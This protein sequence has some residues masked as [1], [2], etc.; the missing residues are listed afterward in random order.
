MFTSINRLAMIAAIIV[1]VLVLAAGATGGISSLMQTNAL[2]ESRKATELATTNLRADMEH[3]AIRG[4]VMRAVLS[5][6]PANGIA[7]NEVAQQLQKEI[8]DIHSDIRKES[9]LTE[10]ADHAKALAEVQAV[11]P[12]YTDS[13]KAVASYPSDGDVT[14]F[15]RRI[16]AFEHNFVELEGKMGAVSQVIEANDN[17]IIDDADRID[18]LG[19]MLIVVATGFCLIAVT[20]LAWGARR[21][22]VNPLLDLADVTG[23]IADGDNVTT[24]AAQ[25]RH[26]ELGKMAEALVKLRQANIRKIEL[27]AATEKA[28]AEQIQT[29]G[30]LAEGL[31]AL[32][33]GKMDF[34]LSNPFA[35]DYEALR[36]NFNAAMD[37]FHEALAEVAATATSIQTGSSEI[38]VASNDLSR[39]T[40]QQAAAL[41]ETAAATDQINASMGHSARHAGDASQAVVTAQQDA[42]QGGNVAREAV[43][44]MSEIERSSQ[45]ISEIITVIDG[46]AFQTNLLAL[47]AGVE[48]ARTGEA[49]RGFAVVASEVRALAQRSADAAKDIKTLIT[50]SS[51]QVDVG[52]KLVG[53]TG[54]A[55]GRI[56]HQ[57]NDISK[58]VGQIAEAAQEQ[59]GGISQVNGAISDMDKMTQQNAAMVEESTAAA[60]SLAD[61]ADRL[62]DLVNRFD[63]GQAPAAAK[64]VRKAVQASPAAQK[65]PAFRSHGNLAL[66]ADTDM[67][68]EF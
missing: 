15:R 52:V 62:A 59:A 53:Q 20:G 60:R 36:T 37:A 24:I 49:G 23:R 54:D 35:D 19:L 32:A 28:R 30:A 46:I 40:E 12:R 39:R 47:N 17:R 66:A 29:V 51:R 58:L 34:R 57:V 16:A 61:E 4:T 50:Q 14:E 11:L 13:A 8:A 10:W 65:R 21:K 25:G 48:A 1:V 63:L 27:E 42:V 67:W 31:Q 41:E 33:D 55:L 6:D 9:E 7:Q 45:Q 18:H 68:T 22:L 44:A 5:K 56:V 2:K 26:D 43:S 64:P 3:D 38:S